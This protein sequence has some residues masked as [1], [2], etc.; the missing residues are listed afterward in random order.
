M[1]GYLVTTSGSEIE[2]KEYE[3]TF[4]DD[5]YDDNI[6]PTYKDAYNASLIYGE[7]LM[8]RLEQERA[9]IGRRLQ[10]LADRMEE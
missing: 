10:E 9:K 4:P 2:I 8:C 1:K 3:M 7:D 5:F 6:F